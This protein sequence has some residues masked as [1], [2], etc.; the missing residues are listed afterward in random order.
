MLCGPTSL[1]PLLPCILNLIGAPIG[2]QGLLDAQI[3]SVVTSDSSRELEV[4]HIWNSTSLLSLPSGCC[5]L[6]AIIESCLVANRCPALGL[7]KFRIFVDEL[8]HARS[9]NGLVKCPFS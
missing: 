6:L 5:F 2:L 1:Y 8:G 9:L 4:D 3:I 7:C